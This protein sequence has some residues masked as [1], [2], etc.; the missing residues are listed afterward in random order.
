MCVRETRIARQKTTSREIFGRN[1]G[2]QVARCE[3]RGGRSRAR[4]VPPVDGDRR[5]VRANVL[6]DR[7]ERISSYVGHD[8][9][10]SHGVCSPPRELPDEI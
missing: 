6:D 7:R 9:G 8:V 2:E 1:S 10:R 3:E 5:R 4:S